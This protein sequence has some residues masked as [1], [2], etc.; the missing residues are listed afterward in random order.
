MTYLTYS[1]II[2]F[3]FCAALCTEFTKALKVFYES[4]QFYPRHFT[5][6]GIRPENIYIYIYIFSF[7]NTEK[8][9]KR[10]ANRVRMNRK[11]KYRDR[12]IQ[13]QRDT[14]TERYKDR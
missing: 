7:D 1:M 8:R 2:I 6:H 4:L 12:E 10:H 14:E 5:F 13:R 3:D 11:F 9:K